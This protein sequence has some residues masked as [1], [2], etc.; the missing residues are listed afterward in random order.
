V[1]SMK[2]GG[3]GSESCHPRSNGCG[4]ATIHWL[5]AQT[6]EEDVKIEGSVCVTC[7][8]QRY[9]SIDLLSIRL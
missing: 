5:G 4:Y 8:L 6:E 3:G 9:S 1:C 2:S 7:F